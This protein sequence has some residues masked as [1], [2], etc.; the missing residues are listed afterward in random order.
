MGDSSWSATKLRNVMR[1]LLEL[2][3]NSGGKPVARPA[4]T[5]SCFRDFEHEYNVKLPSAYCS[6]LSYSNGGHPELDSFR[7]PN[8]PNNAW[9]VNEFLHLLDDRTAS[10]WQTTA[11]WSTIL[12][13]LCI[14]FA[15]DGGGNV[16]YMDLTDDGS[17]VYLCLH[18]EDFKRVK[19]AP[20]FEAF[21]DALEVDPD[22][23]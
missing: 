21:I 17:E 9:G 1:N 18:D 19:I 5:D 2:N 8:D 16:Y 14:P 10:L 4:P 11:Q 3:M 6:L 12:G 7:D 22:M 20:S 23:L 13:A 15:N